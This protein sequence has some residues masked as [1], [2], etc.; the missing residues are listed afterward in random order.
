MCRVLI[1]FPEKHFIACK[2]TISNNVHFFS[3]ELQSFLLV[4]RRFELPDKLKR[5]NDLLIII[6]VLALK[7]KRVYTN[8]LF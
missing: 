3:E 6:G 8:F 2:I 5:H 4:F 7:Y 1:Y